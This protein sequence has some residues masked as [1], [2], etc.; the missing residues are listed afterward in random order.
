MLHYSDG[1]IKCNLYWREEF[2]ELPHNEYGELKNRSISIPFI[3]SY[4][5]EIEV[6]FKTNL[7]QN[8]IERTTHFTRLLLMNA[9]T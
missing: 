2:N 4:Q 3:N 9:K 5:A 7:N 8:T 1:L 6:A